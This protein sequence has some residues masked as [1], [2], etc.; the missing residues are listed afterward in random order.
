MAQVEVLE[1]SFINGSMHEAGDI[2]EYDGEIGSNL[3]LLGGKKT[4]KGAT[5]PVDS[6]TGTQEP[7][8]TEDNQGK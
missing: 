5:A 2:V 1:K 6:D 4:K 8:S 7:E 3:K